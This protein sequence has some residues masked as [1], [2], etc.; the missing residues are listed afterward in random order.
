MRR[1]ACS[2][3]PIIPGAIYGQQHMNLSVGPLGIDSRTELDKSL[4]QIQS[5]SDD[6]PMECFIAQRVACP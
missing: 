6:A 5:T 1:V 3:I 2:T 4:D